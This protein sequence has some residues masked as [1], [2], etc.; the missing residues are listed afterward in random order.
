[1]ALLAACT[2]FVHQVGFTNATLRSLV[3]SLWGRPYTAAQMTYDLRRLREN[4]LISR[5]GKSRTFGLTPE[6]IRVAVFYTKAFNRI[7]R[8]LLAPDA[9]DA[10]RGANLEVARALSILDRTVHHYVTRSG[11]AA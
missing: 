6:G 1:M 8:P 9:P 10:P 5:V 2:Q 3:A 11:A 4:G 7:V